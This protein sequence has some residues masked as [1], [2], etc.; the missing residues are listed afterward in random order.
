MTV[1]VVVAAVW[2]GPSLAQLPLAPRQDIVSS[3]ALKQAG[4]GKYWA[5][6]LP[7][8]ASDKVSAVHLLDDNLY[9][10]TRDGL[11]YAVEPGTGLLRWG[12]FL[13]ERFFRDRPP[14]HVQKDTSDGPVI[15]ISYAQAWVLDRYS[16]DVI[17]RIELPF[18]AGGAAVADSTCM[19]LGSAGGEFYALR[20]SA[21][22]CCAP[23]TRWRVLVDGT[24]VSQPVL[25]FYDRI[26]FVADRGTV[27][28]AA[29]RNKVL[30]WAYRTGGR[31]TGGI[32]VDESGVYVADSDHRLYVLDKDRGQLIRSYPLPGPLFETPVVAQRTV[33]QY[34]DHQGVFAFDVDTRDALWHMPQ[35][36]RFVA[37]AAEQLVLM[38][39]TGDLLMAHNDTGGVQ[40]T[41]ILGEG[42]MVAENRR[43]AVLYMVAPNGRMLCAKPLGFPY[44]RRQAVAGA[45]ATLHRSPATIKTDAEASLDHSVDS[46]RSPWDMVEDPLRS[47]RGS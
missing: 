21:H 31:V 10:R 17:R 7:L 13:D 18:P 23:L 27:Y 40:H 22:P 20:W 25:T 35:A 41:I 1:P 46:L 19:Y 47:K 34:C 42:I 5:G 28:C 29:A 8:T 11:V 15:F 16:G 4:Y 43:D 14:T 32:H 12:E 2:V 6:S 9:V 39:E 33:Y 38:A 37:R 3:T 26:Y 44:L 45:R 30:I 24:V 36:R